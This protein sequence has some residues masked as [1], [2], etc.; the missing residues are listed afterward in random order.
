MQTISATDFKA[1][2]LAIMDDVSNTGESIIITK[3]G[4]P[5]AQI[6]PIADE[7]NSIFGICTGGSITGDII[8]PVLTE[9]E[10]ELSE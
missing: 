6:S 7:T 9:V 1:K 10:W 2:C 4:K 5:I 3:R 8:E